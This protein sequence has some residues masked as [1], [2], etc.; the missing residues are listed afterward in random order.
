[1]QWRQHMNGA[2]KPRLIFVIC[3]MG[4]LVFSCVSA[5]AQEDAAVENKKYMFIDEVKAGMKGHGLTVFSGTEIE[6]FDVEIISILYNLGARGDLILARIDGGPIEKAGVIAGMS[7]SPIYIDDRIIGALAYSW[8]FSKEAIA[9]ITPIEEMLRIFDFESPDAKN[10]S[11]TK[12]SVPTAWAQQ[13]SLHVTLPSAMSEAVVMRPI[14]TPVVFSGFSSEA[15]EY[16]RPQLE[17]W[18]MVPMVGGSFSEKLPQTEASLQEGAA[19]GI[20][21]VRGDMDS[22]AIGTVTVKDG[23]KVLAFGHPFMSSGSVDL[24]MTTAFI[25]TVLPSIVVSSKV[26]TPLESVGALTQD[27]RAGVAGV[28]GD[29]VAMVPF[30][31]SVRRTGSEENETFNFE[32]ARNRQMF[33]AM[34]SMVL[35][36]ALSRVGSAGSEFSAGVSYEIGLDGLPTIRNNDFISGRGRFPSYISLGL[37]ADLRA[38]LEN[39]FAEISITSISMDIEVRET[40]EQA[41][42]IGARVQ[43]DT[44]EPGEGIELKIVMKPYSKGNIE[45]QVRVNIPEHFPEGPAFLYISAAPQTAFFE[46]MRVPYRFRPANIEGLVKLIDEDY[47]GN[48]IDVRM[49]VS[50]PGM[51]VDGHEMPALPSSV[52]S[53]LSQAMGRERVDVT[54]ASVLLEEQVFMEFEVEGAIIIP[55]EI[56]RT[57]RQKA[58]AGKGRN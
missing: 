55:I 52:F 58:S 13:A 17:G 24:P 49:L 11:G 29:T 41:H 22:A 23:D 39:Q 42:I 35:G 3:L 21:M 45:E 38:L 26:G 32:I 1:M 51:V 16:F 10:S 5:Y 9:G 7:G 43:K 50:D 14:M 36:S 28:L 19:V 8:A 56:K 44:F 40:V 57:A 30:S 12:A 46:R 31:L 53:V 15:I 2:E 6:R 48:R 25:H 47:P 4:L 27:R 18:G 20:Q 34:T 37:F 33:P 54:R